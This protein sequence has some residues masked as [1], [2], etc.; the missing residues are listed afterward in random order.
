[1]DTD[2]DFLRARAQAARAAA[3]DLDGVGAPGSVE[4]NARV[5]RA[6]ELRERAARFEA[7]ARELERHAISYAGMTPFSPSRTSGAGGAR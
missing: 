2:A 3:C 1:M 4:A 5:E 7:I 6:R